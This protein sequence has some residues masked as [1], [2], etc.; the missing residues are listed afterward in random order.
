MTERDNSQLDEVAARVAEGEAIDWDE[1]TRR[2]TDRSGTLMELHAIAAVMRAHGT[3]SAAPRATP[4]VSAPVIT[5]AA[6]PVFTWGGLEVRELLGAGG[7]GEVYRAYDPEL[8]REVALKLQRGEWSPTVQARWLAEARSL[9]RVQDRHV[10]TIHGADHHDGRAGLWTELVEGTT[11]E[12][13]IGRNGVLSAREATLAGLALCEALA[14]VHAAGLVHGDVKTRNV[15]RRSSGANAGDL[16]LM[17]FGAAHV[18]VASDRL[19]AR[20]SE[21]TPFAAAPELLEGG[22][23]SVQSDLYALGVLLFRLATLRH[24]HEASSLEA[25]KAS[26]ELGRGLRLR[27]LRP[28]LPRE[29]VATVERL[30]ERDP[31][32]RFATAAELESALGETLRA[33]SPRRAVDP[34]RARGWRIAAVLVVLLGA[35]LLAR[36]AGWPSRDSSARTPRSGDAPR[37]ITTNSQGGSDATTPGVATTTVEGREAPN[38]PA[39]PKPAVAR[40]A[41]QGTSTLWRLRDGEVLPITDGSRLA[42]GDRLWL[43]YSGTEAAHVYVLDED[44]ADEMY[45]LYPCGGSGLTN[46]LPAGTTHHLPGTRSAAP[47][48]WVVTSASGEETFLVVAGRQPIPALEDV[49][50]TLPPVSDDR[51]VEYA[52][53]PPD[54]LQRMRGVAGLEREA[55]PA[56]PHKGSRLATL[57]AMLKGPEAR[58]DL[59]VRLIR[60]QNPGP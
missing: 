13:W 15:M 50:A 11:L 40:A 26:H 23:A 9:A 7:F 6:T 8:G 52:R 34:G 24:P 44:S 28:D 19:A 51:E 47:L 43:D 56:P 38:T 27:N 29:F 35:G 16:V 12:S 53:L 20:T 46:P 42:P 3:E 32:R 59:W 60:T 55:S 58:P 49:V 48:R 5:A 57:A 21:S 14:A 54:M 41:L 39:T 10:L 30:L 33:A 45:V 36:L 1:T 37:S 17:D 2:L 18:A 31:S 25:L 4:D 22:A